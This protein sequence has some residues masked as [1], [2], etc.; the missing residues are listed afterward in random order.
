[1][2]SSPIFRTTLLVALLLQGLQVQA[3]TAWDEAA[4][5]DLSN[6][7]L[8]PTPLVL[9]A[10]SNEVLGSVGNAGLGVDRDYFSFN[11]AAGMRLTAIN[12]NV[13]TQV[14]GSASFMAV[15]AGP[16]VTVTP[17]GGGAAALLGFTHYEDADVGHN[18]LPRLVSASPTLAGS[19]GA[20][21]YS[22]WVQDTGGV[23]PYNFSFVITAVPEPT[24]VVLMGAG[25]LG[26]LWARRRH[27]QG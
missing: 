24:S 20:G 26:L 10:G 8:A 16:Q 27:G 6:N 17:T 23:V 11:V 18:I 25:L 14:S 12:V 19:L 22:M 3:T 4:S 9:A 15:Q 7:G 13:G 1:M 21:T 5:G 2:Q